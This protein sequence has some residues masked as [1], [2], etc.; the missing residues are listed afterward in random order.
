MVDQPLRALTQQ[1][2][3]TGSSEF[4]RE[5]QLVWTAEPEWF[6]NLPQSKPFAQ[7]PKVHPPM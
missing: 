6:P 7:Q 5:V 3:S 4:Q 2:R 1:M